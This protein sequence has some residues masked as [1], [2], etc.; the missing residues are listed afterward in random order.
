M[1]TARAPGVAPGEVQSEFGRLAARTLDAD[2]LAVLQRSPRGSH[3]EI[4]PS[5]AVSERT[6]SRLSAALSQIDLEDEHRNQVHERGSPFESKSLRLLADD[7]VTGLLSAPIYVGR[8]CLGS[9]HAINTDGKPFCRSGLMTSL[10]KHIALAGYADQAWESEDV[11]VPQF[12]ELQNIALM[13]ANYEEFS[14][15][16]SDGIGA[17]MGI[18]RSGVMIW[19]C[20]RQSLQ[21]IPGA[22]GAGAAVTSSYQVAT[23]DLTSNAARVFSSG[24]PYLSNDSDRDPG[25]LHDYAVAFGI[26]RLLSVRLRVGDRPV[27]VLHLA[28]KTSKFTI[29]DIRAAMALASVIAREVDLAHVVF[30]LRS[31]RGIESSLAHA[32]VRIARGEQVHNFLPDT[33]HELAPIIGATWIAFVPPASDPICN[34]SSTTRSELEAAI[35]TDARK[36][37]GERDSVVVP[38][39]AGDPGYTT[40][41]APIYFDRQRIG[42]LSALRTRGEPFEP[43]ERE[44]VRRLG[45]LIALAWATERYQQQRAVVARL[46]ERQRIADD[47]H[48]RVAQLLYVAQIGIDSMLESESGSDKL[49]QELTKVRSLL[50]RGDS[51]IRAVIHDLSQTRRSGFVER[52]TADVEALEQEY[53]LPVHLQV[54]DKALPL[55]AILRSSTI[56]A[57]L[58]VAREIVVNAARHAGP[59]RVGVLVSAGRARHLTIA[60]ADDGIGPLDGALRPGYGLM[61][62]RRAMRDVGGSLRIYRGKQGGVK[63]CATVPV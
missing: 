43:Y 32:A 7:G 13:S 3:L 20:D 52:L 55:T 57:L 8:K 17:A 23:S 45:D 14:K 22:F 5:G 6:A 15:S 63:V 31:Q 27:G 54:E 25:V 19:D 26:R 34:Q 40:L 4:F 30:D 1:T 11:Q 51:S 48:D 10:A 61:S 37:L 35:I 21:V 50:V 18:P 28:N 24:I 36:P 62:L 9:L 39:Q 46:R 49:A 38:R 2:I 29:D 60:I 58:L 33:L 47:L 16:L 44:A 53:S 42:T 41:H 56:D 59:C 12:T